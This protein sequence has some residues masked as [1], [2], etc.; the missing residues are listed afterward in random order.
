MLVLFAWM[1][2]CEGK[3]FIGNGIINRKLN[4][5][6]GSPLNAFFV[7]QEVLTQGWNKDLFGQC[8]GKRVYFLLDYW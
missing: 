6:I 1:N 3:G 8:V 4:I 7:G 2:S 5:Y